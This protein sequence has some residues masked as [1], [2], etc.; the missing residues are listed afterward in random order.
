VVLKTVVGVSRE[1]KAG[2]ARERW[3]KLFSWVCWLH[4]T[5][6]SSLL[7]WWDILRAIRQ[8]GRT[9]GS[10]SNKEYV[11]FTRL[12]EHHGEWVVTREERFAES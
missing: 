8:A 5:A 3:N 9:G 10:S 7:D 1:V 4:A 12:L 6:E 2:H 11:T